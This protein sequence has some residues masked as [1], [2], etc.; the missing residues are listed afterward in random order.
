MQQSL[1]DGTAAQAMNEVVSLV[2]PHALKFSFLDPF[3]LP[4]LSFDIIVALAS[5]KQIIDMLVHVRPID[6]RCKAVSCAI[7]DE[8]AFASMRAGRAR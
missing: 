6:L 1:I 8:S 2:N 7:A 5:L 3:D 4:S